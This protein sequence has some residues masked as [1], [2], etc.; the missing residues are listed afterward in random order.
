MNDTVRFRLESGIGYLTLHRP[1]ARNSINDDLVAAC[2]Q[3]IDTHRQDMNVLVLE[4]NDDFFCA[5][6]DFSAIAASTDSD[7]PHTPQ[8][9]AAALYD[10]WT[11]LACGP[12]VSVAHV[13]GVANAGGVGFAAA[14]DIAIADPTATFALSELIFGLYPACVWPFLTRRIGTQRAQYMTLSTIPI[15][16][17]HAQQW[18]LVDAVA[19]DSQDLLRRHLLRLRRI[20]KRGVAQF[21]AY[22]QE[23]DA[24]L[25]AARP[26]ALQH[27]QAMFADRENLNNIANFIAKGTFPT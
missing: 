25:K 18:G 24:Q 26:I 14:C 19:E 27:N 8:N 10:L 12:F 15:N 7:Q 20:S 1:E 22:R 23:L 3:A 2:Q 13:R 6:G 11:D 4:G 9:H 16:A 21:K 5:G 17:A